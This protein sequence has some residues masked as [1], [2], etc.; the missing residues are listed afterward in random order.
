MVV[1]FLLVMAVGFAVMVVASQ[2]AVASAS[3]LAAGSNLPPFF[4]GI[5]LLAL[6]TDLPEIA[7]SIVASLTDHGDVMVGN[8]VGS[9]AT[10]MTL[11]LGLLPIIA[12]AMVVPRKGIVAAGL[13]TVAS[14]AV[15]LAFVGDGHIGR[16]DAAVLIGIWVIG[17]KT[18]Y[19]RAA[20]DQQLT[21]AEPSSG[22]LGHAARALAALGVVGGAAIVALW[23]I[24]EFAEEIDAPEFL[25]SFF[26]ASFGTSL[27]ELVFDITAVRRGAVA[28]AIGDVVGSSFVDSALSVG[29]GPLIAP[30]DITVDEVRPAVIASLVAVAIVVLILARIKEHDWRTG[31]ILVG[32]YLGFFA[33]LL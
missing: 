18:V 3:A 7:N 4:I 22:R 10:Q 16:L 30:T 19:D 11:V 20:Q 9:A 29:I 26:L 14:M 27:P 24:V 17:S 23:A 6:G 2:R 32:L 5:T 21:I 8:A 12:G 28:L 15:V 13:W 1:V 33:V 31:T 25:V